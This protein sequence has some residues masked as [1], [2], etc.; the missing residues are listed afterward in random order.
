MPSNVDKH[1]VEGEP[2]VRLCNYVDVYKNERI[3]DGMDFMCATASEAQIAR[4]SLKEQ[5][6]IVTKDSE[7]PTDI[8][9][10]A[11]V[12]NDIDGVVCGYH[13]AIFRPDT[14]RLYGG[15]LHW[16]LQ[17]ADVHAHYSMAA[18][19][20][21]RYALSVSDLGSTPLRVPPLEAQ[22]RIATFLDEQTARI[23]VLIAEKER[24]QSVLEEWRGAELA[25]ICFGTDAA[26]EATGN[27]WISA[28]PKGW[29][30]VRLKHVVRGVEQGWS[31]ECESRTAEGDE[32]G[33][34]KAGA[35][36][37]GRY[38]D[39]EHKAL[40]ASLKPLPELE[41]R[42]G[43][44]LVSRA[45]GS[46]D[47]VGSFAF[48][49]ETRPRLMLSDK[50]FRLRFSPEPPLMPELL[51]WMCNTG[52]VREQVR[53]YVSGADGL[54]KNIGAGSLREIW[55][56]LPPHGLQ[57][58]LVTELQQVTFKLDLLQKH[59]VEHIS[60]LREYRS[61]LISAAVTG[62]LDIDTFQRDAEMEAA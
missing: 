26:T 28:L 11:Y 47:L 27:D 18:T 51:A 40:P 25:R 36:N 32:W 20:I 29:R 13:L 46:A 10:P 9:V 55:L 5:D 8:G 52:T 39:T 21:S 53:Q 12:P 22:T 6:V 44:V 24:L 60:R 50:N 15:F 45:S 34:L 38:R 33:V 56:A 23:D 19:G 49:Y 61:S 42:A 62:Q 35:S 4:F 7:E 58:R 48:V 14:E 30:V 1:S 57:E 37:G 17:S 54:A 31:P 59:V 2:P 43:D 41:V 3:T 16:A